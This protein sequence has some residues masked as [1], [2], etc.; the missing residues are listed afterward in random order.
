MWVDVPIIG[1]FPVITGIGLTF[2]YY[3]ENINNPTVQEVPINIMP[4]IPVPGGPVPVTP[5][6]SPNGFNVG[7]GPD[8]ENGF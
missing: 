5:E 2:T 1:T 4:G 7:N 3:P 8:V 6:G